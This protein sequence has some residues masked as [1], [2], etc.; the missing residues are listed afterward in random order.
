M[1]LKKFFEKVGVSP[2]TELV[3]GKNG[4]VSILKENNDP[5]SKI[6]SR[7]SAASALII[8][9]ITMSTMIDYA[10]TGQVITMVSF[11]FLGSTLLALTTFNKK[12]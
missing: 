5:N 6:S 8:A 11:A 2:I 10:V 3:A 12:Q 4:I 9:A 1:F 7:K